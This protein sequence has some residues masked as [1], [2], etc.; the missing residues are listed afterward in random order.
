[1]RRRSL[2][3]RWLIARKLTFFRFGV[4]AL[5]GV[6][7]NAQVVGESL[8]KY[9]DLL[10]D[11]QDGDVPDEETVDSLLAEMHENVEALG[12]LLSG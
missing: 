2:L 9:I 10:E 5:S 4:A 1:M 3:S 6:W 7:Q 8:D 11:L 12:V